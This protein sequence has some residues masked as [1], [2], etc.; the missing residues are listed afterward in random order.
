MP[1]ASNSRASFSASPGEQFREQILASC[2]SCLPCSAFYDMHW[3][4]QALIRLTSRQ[5]PVADAGLAS[6]AT[7][8]AYNTNSSQASSMAAL[9]VKLHPSALQVAG[10]QQLQ[11]H[12]M[13][14]FVLANLEA[15]VCACGDLW[16]GRSAGG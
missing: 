15:G 16:Q 8:D 7:A 3:Q 1:E 5:W 10:G 13:A 14:G 12:A 2:D 4:M 11:Q 6:N 9:T